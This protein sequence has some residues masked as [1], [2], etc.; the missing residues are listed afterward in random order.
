M[1]RLKEVA[2]QVWGLGVREALQVTESFGSDVLLFDADDGGRYVIKNS[3][4]PSNGGREIDALTALASHERVP[5]LLDYRLIAH[6]MYLLIE[7]LDG[8][9]WVSIEGTSP[10][11][12][13]AVGIAMRKVHDTRYGSFDVCETW[14]DLLRS[15]ADRY[16]DTIGDMDSHLASQARLALERHMSKV[17]DSAEP[18]L[19]QFDLRPGNILS[20]NGEFVALIDFDSARG[21]HPSMDFFK[22]W[23]QVEPIVPRAMESLLA[24]YRRPHHK[25]HLDNQVDLGWMSMN[26]LGRLMTIYSLYHG[27]AGLAWCYKRDD[28]SGHFPDTN[29]GLISTALSSV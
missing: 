16:H 1:E 21:G 5:N 13:E 23:Q 17:P 9:P 7:G 28:F 29:R 22:L 10:N 18:V 11:F 15:N 4:S 6:E 26:R 14:H 19:V 20:N 8:T 3:F 27:L 24:G 2:E 25:K 12:L